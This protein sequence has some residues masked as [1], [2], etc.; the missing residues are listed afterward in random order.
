MWN[1]SITHS[2]SEMYDYLRNHDGSFSP[3]WNPD[4][5]AIVFSSDGVDRIPNSEQFLNGRKAI[6]Y[7]DLLQ[8]HR[9]IHIRSDY[10]NEYRLL[11]VPCTFFYF[12]TL[13][14]E[15]Y[16][17]SFIRDYFHYNRTI[18]N[19]AATVRNSP[20]FLYF[21]LSARI[22]HSGNCIPIW[23]IQCSSYQT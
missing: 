8:S 3:Q 22:G 21:V 12:P 7:D 14:W 16:S 23:A 1:R 15:R 9:N 17:H 10:E 20:F 2:V 11:A 18:F 19:A 13:E 4:N 6:V 5:Q